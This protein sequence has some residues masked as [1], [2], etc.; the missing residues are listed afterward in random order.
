MPTEFD[1]E[2]RDTRAALFD[3][4][5]RSERLRIELLAQVMVA[6]TVDG[7]IAGEDRSKQET[8]SVLKRV[9]AGKAFAIMSKAPAQVIQVGNG[10]AFKFRLRQVFEIALIS[11]LADFGVAVEIGN[12]LAHRRPPQLALLCLMTDFELTRIVDGRFHS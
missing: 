4:F 2:S 11:L 10:F 12:A 9:E 7:E 5:G 8:I 6:K 3:F 1:D